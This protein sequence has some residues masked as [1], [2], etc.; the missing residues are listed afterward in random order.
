[1]G[2]HK[3]LE[4]GR[5]LCAAISVF[6]VCIDN[7]SLAVHMHCKIFGDGFLWESKWFQ[8]TKKRTNLNMIQDQL[9]VIF[10]IYGK[11]PNL[12]IYW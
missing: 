8:G 12:A 7:T 2:Y 1:M 4:I 11:Q 10:V 5:M 6:V 3:A 9:K